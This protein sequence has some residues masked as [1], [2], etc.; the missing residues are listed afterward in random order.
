ME[1]HVL[2]VNAAS[3]AHRN[4]G[5]GVQIGNTRGHAH[6]LE[7][8]SP[9]HGRIEHKRIGR[10]RNHREL[11]LERKPSLR[12]RVH[13]VHVFNR[14]H[15]AGVEIEA[16]NRDGLLH[17]VLD[18]RIGNRGCRDR[19][20]YSAGNVRTHGVRGDVLR[21]VRVDICDAARLALTIRGLV[22]RVVEKSRL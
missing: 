16:C 15:V 5:L 1:H 8:T 22:D 20:V 17:R 3:L 9:N 6:V 19:L 12:H 10:V 4:N 18:R 13:V 2:A 7:G 11:L 21:H 14:E